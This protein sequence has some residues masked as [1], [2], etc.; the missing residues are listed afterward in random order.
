MNPPARFLARLQAAVQRRTEAPA[1]GAAAPADADVPAARIERI[2]ERLDQ[3]ERLV[4]GLQDSVYRE[5][6]RQN[7]RVD[8]LRE[9]LEPAEIR[10][11]LSDD[12]RRRGL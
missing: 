11:A 7:E 12:A 5:S 9:R 2:E 8:E 4:E 10:K 3:L 6:V 1:A